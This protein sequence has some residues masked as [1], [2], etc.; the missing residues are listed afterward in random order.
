[1]TLFSTGDVGGARGADFGSVSTRHRLTNLRVARSSAP[2]AALSTVFTSSTNEWS[3]SAH[4]VTPGSRIPS[5]SFTNTDHTQRSNPCLVNL[6]LHDF[7]RPCLERAGL[8]CTVLLKSIS[9]ASSLLFCPTQVTGEATHT[10][11]QVEEEDGVTCGVCGR[12]EARLGGRLDGRLE[13]RLPARLLGRL[14][15]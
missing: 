14:A 9:S 4:D 8:L 2:G 1:M 12:L 5:S 6:A 13:G 11:S 3:S 10:G 15:V 7:I